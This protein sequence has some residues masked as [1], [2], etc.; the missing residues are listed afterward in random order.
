MT[1]HTHTHTHTH[2]ERERERHNNTHGPEYLVSRAMSKLKAQIDTIR[3]VAD[4]RTRIYAADA[5]TLRS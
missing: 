1:I 5:M 4:Q 2:T 3:V